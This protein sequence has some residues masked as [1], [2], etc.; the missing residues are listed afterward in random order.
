ML[1]ASMLVDVNCVQ[2]AA[3]VADVLITRERSMILFLE[4]L[5]LAVPLDAEVTEYWLELIRDIV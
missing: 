5:P 1:E 2:F 3:L 4:T